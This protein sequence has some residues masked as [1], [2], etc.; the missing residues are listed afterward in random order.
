MRFENVPRSCVY[1]LAV[2]ICG[3]LF[4]ALDAASDDEERILAEHTG[5]T[6]ATAF[7]L[8]VGEGDEGRKIASVKPLKRTLSSPFANGENAVRPAAVPEK[9]ESAAVMPVKSAGQSIG[10]AHKTAPL[11]CKGMLRTDAQI[12]LF[13]ND[14]QQDFTLG[15]GESRHGVR[16]IGLEGKQALMEVRGERIRIPV[17]G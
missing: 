3:F 8:H 7:A 11:I 10:T 1:L 17:R 4:Y 13:L 6:A 16:V 12:V 5:G 9:T 15:I 14:G 2:P